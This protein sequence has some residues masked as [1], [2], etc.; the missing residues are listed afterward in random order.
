MRLYIELY[1][2]SDGTDP[3]EILDIMRDLG[4]DPVVGKYDFAKDYETPEEYKE[5]INELTESLEGSK[6]R[7]RLTT[8]K[9]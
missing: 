7:Y 4:F 1:F 2:H 9:E 3:L 8:R 6:V 5:I